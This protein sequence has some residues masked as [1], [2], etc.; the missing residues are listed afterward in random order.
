MSASLREQLLPLMSGPMKG[1]YVLLALA[2]AAALVC[3][4]KGG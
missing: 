2:L 4:V 1:Y 3:I